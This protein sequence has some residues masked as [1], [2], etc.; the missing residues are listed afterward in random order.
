MINTF[1]YAP[2]KK[3]E[4]NS[5]THDTDLLIISHYVSVSYTTRSE[6]KSKSGCLS[7]TY[8]EEKEDDYDVVTGPNYGVASALS[9]S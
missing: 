2:K 5:C 8:L 6:C 7:P 9:L 1:L 4:E 3:G